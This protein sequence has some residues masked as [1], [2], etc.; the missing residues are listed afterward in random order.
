[1]LES[2]MDVA[3]ATA[4][5]LGKPRFRYTYDYGSSTRLDLRV[6]DRRNGRADPGQPVRMLARNDP[7]DFACGTCGQRATALCTSCGG[8]ATP[9][10]CDG[11][12]AE[13]ACRYAMLLPVVNSP[14]MG[15]CGYTGPG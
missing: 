9:F 12:A 5:G 13:H 15:V 8:G 10:F 2:Y 14:R 11:H 7:Q 1:M 6:V 4:I 3:I